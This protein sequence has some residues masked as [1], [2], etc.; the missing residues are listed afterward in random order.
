MNV[1]PAFCSLQYIRV[2]L[3]SVLPSSGLD[4]RER[5]SVPCRRLRGREKVDGMRH[6]G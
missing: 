3:K 6:P 2:P 5:M 1:L 4:V